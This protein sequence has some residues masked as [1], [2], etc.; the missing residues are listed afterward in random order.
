[1]ANAINSLKFGENTYTFTLPY[2]TCSTAAGTAAK[3]VD[4]DNFSLETGARILVKFSVTNTA[5]SPTLNVESTGAKAIY[6][7]GAAITAGYLKA[8]KTYEFVYNGT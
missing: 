4:V 2:G 8:N 1:M 5:S 6:Y 3:T 7:N